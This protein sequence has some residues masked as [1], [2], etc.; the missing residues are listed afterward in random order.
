MVLLTEMLEKDLTDRF[1][2]GKFGVSNKKQFAGPGKG[3]PNFR[4]IG[5][6]STDGMERSRPSETCVQNGLSV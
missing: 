2:L 4:D 3:G 1:C 6:L 5:H